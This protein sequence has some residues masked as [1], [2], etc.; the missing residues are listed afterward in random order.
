MPILAMLV[1]VLIWGGSFIATK[2]AVADIPP[3]AFAMLRFALAVGGLV[4]VHLLSRTP[5]RVARDLWRPVLVAALTGVTLT[6]VLENTALQ[7]TSAGNSALF[8]AASPLVTMASAVL[9]LKERLTWRMGVGSC[10]AFGAMVALVGANIQ[11]TGLGDMLMAI[12]TLV[13]AVYVM[14]SKKLADRMSPLT[15]L[16]VT[17]FIGTVAL[18]PC[19]G[20][21]AWV[22]R[23]P[24]HMTP[25]VVWALLFLGLGSSCLAYWLW[26]Y[27]LGRMSAATSGLY[28]YLM[29]V[30]TLL[31]SARL[32]GEALTP[33]KLLEACLILLGVYVAVS[34]PVPRRIAERVGV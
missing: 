10:L 33:L 5:L 32:L 1:A 8:I 11:E 29:P 19:A 20:V 16:T 30:V 12:N 18:V 17:F 4:V 7:F 28:L 13:G 3:I 22:T 6:Y 26:M 2:A 9:F 31:L 15:A 24:W 23:A 14:A 21:E 25:T 34:R 27:A